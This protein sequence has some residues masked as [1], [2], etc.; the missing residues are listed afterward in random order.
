MLVSL[1]DTNNVLDAVWADGYSEI[2]KIFPTE[3]EVKEYLENFSEKLVVNLNLDGGDETCYILSGYTPACNFKTRLPSSPFL[4]PELHFEEIEKEIK[5]EG[6]VPDPS[7]GIFIT[8]MSPSSRFLNFDK[9]VEGVLHELS[10]RLRGKD[11]YKNWKYFEEDCLDLINSFLS[12]V[13]EYKNKADLL[14][15]LRSKMVYRGFTPHIY[16]NI[17]PIFD[18]IK[19][20]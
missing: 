3:E 15:S 11:Y 13:D 16:R 9:A 18:I 7:Y 17:L 8:F 19:R 10:F 14:D 4:P 20:R 6:N 2:F 5:S 12:L 1:S